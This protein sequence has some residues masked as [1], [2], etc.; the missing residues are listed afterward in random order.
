MAPLKIV[1]YSW[2]HDEC[3]FKLSNL[4]DP[5]GI[6]KSVVGIRKLTVLIEPSKYDFGTTSE[7]TA[8]TFSLA[9]KH[10][11]AFY[12]TTDEKFVS[13]TSFTTKIE[14]DPNA[15]FEFLVTGPISPPSPTT[16]SPDD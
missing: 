10:Y 11:F 14:H 1:E 13:N 9:W 8:Q 7:V 15:T 2:Q 5:A 12:F 6:F 16:N 4:V 3:Q